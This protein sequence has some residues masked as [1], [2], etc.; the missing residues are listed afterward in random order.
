M[1]A[2]VEA[3]NPN[4]RRKRRKGCPSNAVARWRSQQT[5]AVVVMT[6]TGQLWQREKTGNWRLR[7]GAW[8]AK[9]AEDW[10][11]ATGF[12][13][14]GV[15]GGVMHVEETRATP[16]KRLGLSEPPAPR[17]ERCA[18]PVPPAYRDEVAARIERYAA[19]AAAGLPL[20][21]EG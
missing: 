17:A 14:T 2:A 20:F 1:V 15:I 7:A 18:V 11:A 9:R 12:V 19:R 5:G 3:R 6:A 8:T 13:R 4:M 21:G 10:A 16:I